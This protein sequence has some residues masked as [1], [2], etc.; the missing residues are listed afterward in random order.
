MKTSYES[1]S[2]VAI[3]KRLLVPKTNLADET[4][5][6]EYLADND[7]IVV[8][9]QVDPNNIVQIQADGSGVFLHR[10]DNGSWSTIP[11]AIGVGGTGATSLPAA[12]QNL[13]IA[14][15]D[16]DVYAVSGDYPL[17]GYVTQNLTQ[18]LFTIITPRRMRA[19]SIS[20]VTIGSLSATLRGDKGYLDSVSTPRN[21][22]ASP[23]SAT[24]ARL[25]ENAVRIIVTKNGSTFSNVTNNTPISLLANFSMTFHT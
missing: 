11:N 12:M 15:R 1:K 2:P 5:S 22:L 23:F 6:V 9:H 7:R 24:P 19:G 16:G 4:M 20:R 14:Y 3:R 21:L 17:Y 13:E 25:S 18:L 10:R 8:K